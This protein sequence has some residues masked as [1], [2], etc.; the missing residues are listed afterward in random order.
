MKVITSIKEM[1]ALVKEIKKDKS[2]GFVP[3]MGY[4]HE[5]H[6]QLMQEARLE[7][8][9]VV[10][11]IFVNPLQFGPNDDYDSYPR[12]FERD[13][14]ICSSEGVDIIFHPSA[15]EMYPSPLSVKALV[16][17]RTNVLCGESRP[18]HFDGVATVLTK[19]FNIVQPER[20]Y[21]GMKD[22][23]QVAVVEG[24]ISDFNFPINL[25][26]VGT[27]REEDGLAKSSRNIRLAPEEREEAPE[28]YRSL[29]LAKELLEA[30]ERSKEVVIAK[31]KKHIEEKTT[32]IIDYVEIYSFPELEEYERLEGKIIIALAVKFAN[33]R[34]ID[35][36]VLTVE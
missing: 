6:I 14:N 35:N 7:N 33:A 36:L 29:L 10:V 13:Q 30:G 4:L 12:D 2:I 9:T 16:Q 1:Q 24:L 34:L 19:L 8:D 22:A 5:G 21:L 18:G 3:T 11:S 32:G 25:I 23:Q 26:P 15:E 17:R 31:M 27:V 28:L 20:V